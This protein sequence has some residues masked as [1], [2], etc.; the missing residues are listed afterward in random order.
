MS[1]V[2]AYAYRSAKSLPEQ[3]VALRA[4]TDWQWQER[5][6]ALWGDYASAHASVEELMVKLFADDD[7]YR[8]ELRSLTPQTDAL[9]EERTRSV[10]RQLAPLVRAEEIRRASPNP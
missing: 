10:L 9:W 5:D 7:G 3:L 4:G 1:L 8:V 2:I 6:S